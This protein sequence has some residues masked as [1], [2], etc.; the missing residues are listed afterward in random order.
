MNENHAVKLMTIKEVAKT[1]VMPENTLRRLCK[2]NR[3]PCIKIS[4]RTLICY[5]ALV[6]YLY[7]LKPNK[8]V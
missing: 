2:A 7:N 6:D 5:D 8:E 3:V 1:G 4:N